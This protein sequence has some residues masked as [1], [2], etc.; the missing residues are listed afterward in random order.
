MVAV[1]E[2]GGFLWFYEFLV[3]FCGFYIFFGPGILLHGGHSHWLTDGGTLGFS[4]GF[5]TYGQGGWLYV[6]GFVLICMGLAFCP[7]FFELSTSGFILLPFLGA[8]ICEVVGGDLEACFC[9]CVL[10]SF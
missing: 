8:F 3:G 2:R 4:D 6:A 10:L 9:C 7:S 1:V 5:V